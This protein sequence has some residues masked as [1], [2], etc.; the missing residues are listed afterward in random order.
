MRGSPRSCSADAGLPALLLGGP[1]VLAL[2]GAGA[3]ALN[4]L[5]AAAIL[6]TGAGILQ[7]EPTLTLRFGAPP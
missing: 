4:N 3:R 5:I 2:G 7:P 1:S 6:A